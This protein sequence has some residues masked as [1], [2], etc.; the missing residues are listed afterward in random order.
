M[1][2]LSRQFAQ[3]LEHQENPHRSQRAKHDEFPK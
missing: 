2:S 3:S 1:F